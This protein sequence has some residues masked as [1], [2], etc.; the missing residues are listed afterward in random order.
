MIEDMYMYDLSSLYNT[1]TVID[2]GWQSTDLK[3]DQP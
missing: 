2:N 1:I 3:S